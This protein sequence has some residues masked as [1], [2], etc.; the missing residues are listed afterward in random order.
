VHIIYMTDRIKELSASLKNYAVNTRRHFHEYPE[1]SNQEYET[2]KFIIN[3]LEAMGIPYIMPAPTGVI[4]IIN[5][6]KPGKVL[7]I[8]AD[9]D[10]LPIDEKNEVEFKSKKQGVM[11]ACGHDAH[12]ASLL[13]VA[14]ILNQM[15]DSLNGKV[16][17]IFQPAEEY[18]PSGALALMSKGDLE[19]VNAV[20]GAHVLNSLP[21]GTVSAEEGPR[22]AAS[23][24]LNIN[25]K[26]RGG[27]GGVPHDAIDAIVTAAAIVM[28]IQTIVSRGLD[29]SNSAVISI[30]TLTAGTAKNIIAEE[31]YMTG[32][33]RYFDAKLIEKISEEIDRVVRNTALAYGASAEIEIVPG[34]L[35]IVNNKDLTMRALNSIEKLW[36]SEA[37]ISL[38]KSCGVDDFCYYGLKAPIHYAF[39][40]SRNDATYKNY[41]MHNPNFD[42]DEDVI[43]NIA[44]YFCQFAID[45]LK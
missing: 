16:K 31:A 4:A 25:V 33:I 27:H 11:H 36:G 40:G 28:N 10:A 13:T 3:E 12:A 39:F 45:Y 23:A 6:G 32:T 44:Q 19:D 42:I 17:L 35:P 24:S 29:I 9:I 5:D 37:I 20:I 38:P 41:P 2:T 26:G 34:C 21:I 15:K 30:G 1:L 43:I 8:R 22:M 18:F 14:K 7:G